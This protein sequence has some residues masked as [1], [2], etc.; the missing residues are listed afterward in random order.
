MA[1][2]FLALK[3]KKLADGTFFDGKDGYI[4]NFLSDNL[5][6]ASYLRSGWKVYVLDGLKEVESV[7]TTLETIEECN[8]E[9]PES[10]KS[11]N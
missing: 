9:C 1:H 5:E 2:V 11:D 10:P 8:G 6:V 3:N 4:S 7:T